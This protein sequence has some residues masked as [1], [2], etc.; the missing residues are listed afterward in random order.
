MTRLEREN[1]ELRRQI[2][3]LTAIIAMLHPGTDL[4]TQRRAK[5]IYGVTWLNEKNRDAE[6]SGV[7]LWVRTGGS[8]NSP[9]KY[10]AERLNAILEWE[11]DNG[12]PYDFKNEQYV[13]DSKKTKT[14]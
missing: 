5:A 1:Q 2:A 12:L 3:N 14:A 4:I 11:R 13:S 7:R 9:K 10:S 6:R 8:P